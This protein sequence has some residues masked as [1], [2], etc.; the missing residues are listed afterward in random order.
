MHRFRFH[1]AAS[2][3]R[4]RFTTTGLEV[5]LRYP[6][7]SGRAA[8]MDERIIRA[9]LHA[10]DQEPKLKIVGAEIPAIRIRTIATSSNIR[11]ILPGRCMHGLSRAGTE[12]G[13]ITPCTRVKRFEGF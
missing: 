8:E 1:R 10:I 11:T 5:F 9:L 2:S 4:F 3:V 7:E 6:V 12:P 13:D